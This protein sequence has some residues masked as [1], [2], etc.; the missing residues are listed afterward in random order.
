M[1]FPIRTWRRRP[2]FA[3]LAIV[4]L[5][6]GIG[7][8]T[9][10]FSIVDSVLLRPLPYRQPDRLTAIWLTSTR[11]SSLAKI[12]ATYRD[13][14]EFRRH[15]QTLQQVEAATWAKRTGSVLTGYGPARDVLTIPATAGFFQMLGVRAETGRTFESA[16]ETRACSLVLSHEFW[17]TALHGDMAI[18]GN[19]LILDQH[20]CT[21]VGVMPAGFGFYPRQTQAWILL[22]PGFER[23]PDPMLVGIFARLKNGV[24]REQA[25]DELRSIYRA[26]HPAGE[27][28]NVEPVVYDLQGEFTFLAGRTLRTTL[29]IAFAAVLLVLFIACLNVANLLAATLAERRREWAVRAALGSGQ[30]R[31]IGQVLAETLSLSV[32]GTLLGVGI[33]WAGLRYF[34]AIHP[35]ELRVGADVGINLAVLGFSA[36]LSIAVTIVAGLAP[37]VRASRVDLANQLAWAGRGMI[38]VRQKLA[39][40]I[41]AVQVSFS[42]LLLMGAGLLM[43]SVLRMGSERLGFRPDHILAARVTLPMARYAGEADWRRY[44]DGIAERLQ[45]IPGSGGSAI[46]S[47][48]PP[49]AGG[50]QTLEVHGQ[51][52]PEENR[53]HDIGADSVTPEFFDLLGIAIVRG[54]G[55]TRR[56]REG[57]LAVAV[58]NQALE[59]RYFHGG[60]AIGQQIRLNGRGEWLT[61]VGVCG[62]LKH[63]Q[64]MNEMSWVESPIFYQPFAQAPRSNAQIAVRAADEAAAAAAMRRQIATSDP[65]VPVTDP[66]PL[67]A[68]LTQILAF[69]RFRATLLGLFAASA[70]LLSAVGLHGVLLQ[71]VAQRTQEFG[72]RRAVGAQTYHVLALVARQGG[73]PVL[74]GLAG[75]MAAAILLRRVLASLLYGVEPADPLILGVVAALLL[76]VAA[77]AMLFPA[78]RA[79]RVDPMTALREQ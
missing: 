68:R 35:I 34:R 48:L 4:T 17:K 64:L 8:T 61:I 25:R 54:R 3:A 22:G 60:G 43:T 71:L 41:V 69:P 55:F 47:K 14:A 20:P 75:G 67:E 5:G 63:T 36:G 57:A 59:E 70:L 32:L 66:E 31:L 28:R 38:P 27:F 40:V 77:I 26:L 42:F 45:G 73:V 18:V 46:A 24:T 9:A 65:L 58:V 7:A 76:V 37:A 1:A 74:G 21:V 78:Q 53:A 39:R 50:N 15:T 51:E 44:F 2:G 79:A 30:G 33:A 72:V 52:T 16:D 23:D 10:V 29:L 12:F 13:F 6:L 49:E 11:E 62:N 19:S 56:D